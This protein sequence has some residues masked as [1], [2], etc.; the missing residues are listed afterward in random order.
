[1]ETYQSFHTLASMYDPNNAGRKQPKSN[2]KKSLL[3]LMPSLVSLGSGLMSTIIEQRYN[4]P[5]AQIKRLEKAGVHPNAFYEM[6]NPGDM[7]APDFGLT[8]EGITQASLNK[9]EQI[10]ADELKPELIRE[11]R[12]VADSAELSYTKENIMH[13]IMNRNPGDSTIIENGLPV[14]IL[15]GQSLYERQAF[16]ETEAKEADVDVKETTVDKLA[17]DIDVNFWKSNQLQSIATKLGLEA[18]QLRA[19]REFWYSD[20]KYKNDLLE[21]GVKLQT[22]ALSVTEADNAIQLKIDAMEDGPVKVGF[23][24]IWQVIKM[25]SGSTSKGGSV[26]INPN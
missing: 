14:G 5:S 7:S 16:A 2:D 9:Q 15:G 10:Y 11:Q 26:N 13:D 8:P 3:G 21:L 23:Q 24:L 19:A 17:S 22:N 18:D 12:A 4:S 20:N 1:M 25:F 6:G